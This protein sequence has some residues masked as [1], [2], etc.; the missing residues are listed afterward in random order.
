[1]PAD[2][3]PDGRPSGDSEPVA[4]PG[5]GKNDPEAAERAEDE[6]DRLRGGFDEKAVEKA[7]EQLGRM[8]DRT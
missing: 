7:R 8:R 6:V 2:D 5:G 4:P 1:M 3:K